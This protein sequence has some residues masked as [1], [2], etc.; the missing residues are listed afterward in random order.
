VVS[1]TPRSHFTPG[2]DPVPI[3][4]EGGWAPWPVWTDGKS[5]LHGDS[6]LDRPAHSQLLYGLRYPAHNTYCK[7]DYYNTVSEILSYLLVYRGWE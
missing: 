3:V 1:S 5:R 7:G 6:I 2:T 4:Q